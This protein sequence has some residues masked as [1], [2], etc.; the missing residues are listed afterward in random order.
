MTTMTY[1]AAIGQ[2]QLEAMTEDERVV[3]LGEHI[4]PAAVDAA[5]L[6]H[7]PQ[8]IP[9]TRNPH[10]L[11]CRRR[12][13]EVHQNAPVNAVTVD[14]VLRHLLRYRGTGDQPSDSHRC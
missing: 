1:L 14:T 8:V 12:S 4:N 3:V 7:L 13:A 11:R 2:A 6:I 5:R 10:G 9:Q